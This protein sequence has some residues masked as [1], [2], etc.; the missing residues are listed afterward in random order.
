MEVFFYEICNIFFYLA[1]VS[2]R[3][4]IPICASCLYNKARI[5]KSGKRETASLAMFKSGKIHL[6][7]LEDSINDLCPISVKV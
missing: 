2:T 3:I 5:W 6:K 7:D 4:S 1:E